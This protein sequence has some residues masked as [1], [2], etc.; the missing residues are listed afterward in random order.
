MG[1]AQIAAATTSFSLLS[2]GQQ[3]EDRL[4]QIDFR[5]SKHVNMGAGKRLQV[6]VDLYN[7]LNSSWVYTQ[8]N[9][10]GTNYTVAS[11]WLRPA[12]ILQARM[13]KIGGQLDF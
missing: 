11:T 1:A 4:N 5:V 10:L 13:F 8:N 9:T 6:N 7:A 2:T 3:Y 12:Q